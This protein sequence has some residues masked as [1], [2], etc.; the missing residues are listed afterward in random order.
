MERRNVLRLGGGLAALGLVPAGF[1]RP[2]SAQDKMVL[3]ASDVHPAGYP[4]VVAV[5]NMG[6]KLSAATNG[7][8]SIAMYPSMQLGDEKASIEQ[9]QV[10][11]LA[12]TRVSVGTV[13]PVVDELNV[14]NLPFLF[15]NPEHMEHVIDGPI[16]KEML[17]KVTT[18]PNS[19][20]VG[21]C[22]MDAG[23]RSFYDTKR[24][25]K[26][27]DDLKGLKM[28]VM[29]NPM[30]VD[31]A[32]D[33]GANGVPMG[34]DQVFSGLQTGVIDGAENNPPSFVFDNHYQV[35]KYFTLDEHL[36]VPEMVVMSRPVWDKLSKADQDLIVKFSREAQ[37]DERGL[38]ND[39]EKD[40]YA[41]MKTAGIVVTPIADKTPF[42]KAVKPVWDKY[43]AK[44]PDLIKRI[45]DTK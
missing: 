31:M 34:Y 18:A 10:G 20:L 37:L 26:S 30:F 19:H 35:A 36:I 12:F 44:W 28:R 5:E 42:Q 13:G 15:R 32:N 39:T 17:D 25:I 7:R 29:G 40:A 41:R 1:A 16:G 4:T 8:L 23:A 21:L 27:I 2:A 14:F 22:F 6:K 3:K 24:Q 33:L 38:W 11:A 45:Q 43:G 9:A